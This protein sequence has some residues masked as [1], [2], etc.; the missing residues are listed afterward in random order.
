[1]NYYARKY[2]DCSRSLKLNHSSFGYVDLASDI[3]FTLGQLFSDNRL[4]KESVNH[5]AS[6]FYKLQNRLAD[7]L[8]DIISEQA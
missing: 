5:I 4:P 7:K 8:Y 3:G 6:R 2:L 1:M